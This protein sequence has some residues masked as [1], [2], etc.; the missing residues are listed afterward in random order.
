MGPRGCETQILLGWKQGKGS[1]VKKHYPKDFFVLFGTWP[2]KGAYIC[3]AAWSP[4]EGLLFFV[5]SVRPGSR[6]LRSLRDKMS[7]GFFRDWDRQSTGLQ[8]SSSEHCPGT[9]F[10]LFPRRKPPSGG[11]AFITQGEESKLWPINTPTE[12]RPGLDHLETN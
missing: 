1:S 9:G 5:M 10:D 12:A 7:I 6:T 4:T 8:A 3:V 2:S 11:T